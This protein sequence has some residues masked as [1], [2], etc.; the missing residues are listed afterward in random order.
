MRAPSLF[1]LLALLTVSVLPATAQQASDGPSQYSFNSGIKFRGNFHFNQSR[2]DGASEVPKGENGYG[3]GMEIIGK[4]IGMGLYGFA[5]GKTDSFDAEA[6]RVHAALELNYFL[7][8]QRIRLAPYAGVHT[9]L[10][11]FDKKWTEAPTVPKPQDG[12]R[13]L[14]YQVGFRFKPIP[15]IGV[16]AH[17]RRQSASIA[18]AQGAT[19]ERDQVLIGITLF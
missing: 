1:L 9:G 17:W 4:N 18:G 8:I 2:A 13:S 6:T 14:G 15:V 19:L 12:F 3:V 7:P 10:G 16:D 5:E 11:S